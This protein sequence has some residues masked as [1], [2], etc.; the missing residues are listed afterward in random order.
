MT[1]LAENIWSEPERMAWM[2]PQ[3]LTVS[4]WSEKYR[5]LSGRSAE[6]GPFRLRRTPYLT[7]IMDATLDPNIEIIVFCKPAQ[8]AGTTAMEND[9][10]GITGAI[11]LL[12]KWQVQ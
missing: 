2:P 5:Y 12:G 10:S 3:K 4:E 9:V 7:K 6:S 1:N 8:I 11:L